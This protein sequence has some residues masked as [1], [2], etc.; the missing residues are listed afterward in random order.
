LLGLNKGRFSATFE[1]EI[2]LPKTPDCSPLGQVLGGETALYIAT[3]S[4][5]RTALEPIIKAFP[6]V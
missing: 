3:D 2:Y 4:D 5:N 1:D 6:Q